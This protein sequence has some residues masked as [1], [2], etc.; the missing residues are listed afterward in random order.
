M[1]LWALTLTA[2]LLHAWCSI[3]FPW[4]VDSKSPIWVFNREKLKETIYFYRRA[5]WNIEKEWYYRD[6]DTWW[7][8]YEHS[9]KFPS[10]DPRQ[11]LIKEASMACLRMIWYLGIY[12]SDDLLRVEV[13][14]CLDEL[15]VFYY[16]Q[17]EVLCQAILWISC[18]EVGCL[19]YDCGVKTIREIFE[20]SY[21]KGYHLFEDCIRFSSSGV[22][23]N[24]MIKLFEEWTLI[25]ELLV[26]CCDE[27]RKEMALV[28]L[29]YWKMFKWKF[30]YLWEHFKGGKRK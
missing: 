10:N 5:D 30:W 2:V 13:G 7:L 15:Q 23:R 22:N 8:A 20:I 25:H 28:K 11:I 14:I 29:R 19:E 26:R 16:T 4:V 21:V 17:Y 3:I 18:H 12:I 27:L 24:S 9:L 6:E 1:V